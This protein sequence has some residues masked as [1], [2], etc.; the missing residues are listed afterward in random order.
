MDKDKITILQNTSLKK[1]NKNQ[2][3]SLWNDWN[4][5]RASQLWKL[6]CS[7]LSWSTESEKECVS[8]EAFASPE[9]RKDFANM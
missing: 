8:Q 9:E 6:S 4:Q 1:I 5:V 2:S 3:K 7:E